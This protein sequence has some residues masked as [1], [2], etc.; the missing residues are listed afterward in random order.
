MC[1]QDLYPCGKNKLL[2]LTGP[3]KNRYGEMLPTCACVSQGKRKHQAA[4]TH[5]TEQSLTQ[6]C[7]RE[8]YK[9]T[10]APLYL[11]DYWREHHPAISPCGVRNSQ[12]DSFSSLERRFR[13]TET[14]H[15]GN[16]TVYSNISTDILQSGSAS[17]MKWARATVSTAFSRRAALF[18]VWSRV[19]CLSPPTM[20]GSRRHFPWCQMLI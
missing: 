14:S 6:H 7:K 1:L 16:D 13:G 4:H 8:I 19:T 9:H 12:H 11:R 10:E 3:T 2:T 5:V 15:T 18:Y 17:N 20:W